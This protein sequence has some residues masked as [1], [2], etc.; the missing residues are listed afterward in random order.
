MSLLT[1]ADFRA[2]LKKLFWRSIPYEHSW[3]Y[4]RMGHIGFM[5][6]LMPILRKLYPQD[7]DFKAALKRHMELYNVTPYISTLPMV[8]RRCNGGGQRY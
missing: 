3:N 8:H 1:T 6:A 4:E 5:W 7:A 2:D